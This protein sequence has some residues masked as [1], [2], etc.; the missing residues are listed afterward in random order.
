MDPVTL[1]VCDDLVGEAV[2]N[3]TP[4]FT[5]KGSVATT[6]DLPASGNTKGDLW[7]V[8]ADGSECSWDGSQWVPRNTKAITIADID[9]LFA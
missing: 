5:Y 9:A 2:G 8:R 1:A 7:Q 4:G 6:A 3:L